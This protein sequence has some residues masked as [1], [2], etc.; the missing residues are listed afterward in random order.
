MNKCYISLLALLVTLASGSANAG[1]IHYEYS[2]TLSFSSGT[3]DA[4]LDGAKV[5]INVSFDSSGVYVDSFGYPAIPANNDATVTISGSSQ[6]ANNGTFQ[7][8]QLAFYP[9][10]AGLFTY[11]GGVHPVLTLP[12][13]GDLLFNPATA[14][15]STGATVSVGQT[16][17]L[18]DFV[19]ATSDNYLWQTFSANYNQVSTAL[20][21]TLTPSTVPEPSSLALLGLGGV[22]LA[23]GACRGRRAA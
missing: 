6:A 10:L 4:G 17:S 21:A 16:V 13:A 8:P 12:V 1:T 23:I 20:T 14:P 7:L 3:D 5:N 9:S 19:P 18:S 22:G 11:P 15:S 2:T